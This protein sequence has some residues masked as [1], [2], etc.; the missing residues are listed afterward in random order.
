MDWEWRVHV[1]A[2]ER[3]AGLR[4]LPAHVE[5]IFTAAQEATTDLRLSWKLHGGDSCSLR[6]NTSD[7]SLEILQQL[8][9]EA[10]VVVDKSRREHELQLQRAREREIL[11]AAAAEAAVAAAAAAALVAAKAAQKKESRLQKFLAF[12]QRS[13]DANEW[14]GRAF[15]GGIDDSEELL[16]LLR[17]AKWTKHVAE[18]M[19]EHFNHDARGAFDHMLA[20]GGMRRVFTAAGVALSIPGFELRLAG[21]GRCTINIKDAAQGPGAHVTKSD[22]L[23]SAQVRAHAQV[24]RATITAAVSTGLVTKDRGEELIDAIKTGTVTALWEKR[25]VVVTPKAILVFSSDR[26]ELITATVLQP[27]FK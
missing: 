1:K 21:D 24:W 19:E 13:V 14:L 10:T 11:E 18:R 20:A 22:R 23:T 3:V 12:T 25:A 17:T 15:E 5:D 6:W 9:E 27:G 26:R 4:R 8:L 7:F 16:G 2:G